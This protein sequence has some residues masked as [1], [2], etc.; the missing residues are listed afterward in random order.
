MRHE[1]ETGQGTI[2]MVFRDR[3]QLFT[4]KRR[5]VLGAIAKLIRPK[6]SIASH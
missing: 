5:L 3:K 2:E 4:I 6:G 1:G